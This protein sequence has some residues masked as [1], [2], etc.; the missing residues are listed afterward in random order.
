MLSPKFHVSKEIG[1]RDE[2]KDQVSLH[3]IST[4]MTPFRGDRQTVLDW[5]SELEPDAWT[6]STVVGR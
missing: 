6:I 5:T 1:G 3:G 4:S 2:S